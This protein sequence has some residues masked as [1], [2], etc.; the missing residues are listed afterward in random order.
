MLLLTLITSKFESLINA[1]VD[2]SSFFNYGLPI[3]MTDLITLVSITFFWG[4]I[5]CIRLARVALMNYIASRLANNTT[6][7]AHCVIIIII[8][9]DIRIVLCI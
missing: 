2:S 7:L 3:T 9:I 8:N 5:D 4:L 1:A 6:M